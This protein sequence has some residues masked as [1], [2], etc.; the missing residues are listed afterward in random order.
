MK[1]AVEEM[2]DKEY[3]KRDRKSRQEG[4]KEEALTLAKKMIKEKIDVNLV[5]KI[6]GLKKEQFME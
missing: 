6:T 4:R 2:L 3:A 5:M 1:L